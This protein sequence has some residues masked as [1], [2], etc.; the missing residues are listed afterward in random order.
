[1]KDGIITIPSDLTELEM[2]DLKK[3]YPIIGEAPKGK[4]GKEKASTP[5]PS[6][7]EE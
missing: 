6:V 3:T 2:E 7:K 5:D 4:K 1:V